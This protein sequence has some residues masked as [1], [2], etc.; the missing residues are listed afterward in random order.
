MCFKLLVLSLLFGKV[1]GLE[2]PAALKEK[3]NDTNLILKVTNKNR[4]ELYLNLH[5]KDC[6]I[7]V[8][9]V[10]ANGI[11]EQKLL[12]N[13]ELDLDVAKATL[14]AYVTGDETHFEIKA[15]S[16]KSEDLE[17]VL[18]ISAT[19]NESENSLLGSGKIQGFYVRKAAGIKISIEV[20]QDFNFEI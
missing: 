19:Y 17:A 8:G 4:S 3:I 7:E 1:F 5:Y 18:N 16:F 10:G 15:A 2:N 20:D 12:C 6:E 11:A 14:K 13:L 9:E